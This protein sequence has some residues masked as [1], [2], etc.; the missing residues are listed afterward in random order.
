M[1]QLSEQVRVGMFCS[2][3][4]ELREMVR[5]LGKVL[6]CMFLCVTLEVDLAQNLAENTKDG[7]VAHT[8]TQ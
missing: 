3:H 1:N 6:C 5:K 7:Y 2:K 4:S 8:T